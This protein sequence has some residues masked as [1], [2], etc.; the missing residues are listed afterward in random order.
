MV[1]PAA[2]DVSHQKVNIALKCYYFNQFRSLANRNWI[3]LFLG[4][5]SVAR[6]ANPANIKNPDIFIFLPHFLKINNK[7]V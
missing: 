7:N 3:N 2:L 4:T 1:L 6:S 5:A